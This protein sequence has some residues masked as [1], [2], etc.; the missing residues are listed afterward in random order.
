MLP[1]FFLLLSITCLAQT[2]SVRGRVSN[3]AGEALTG[4]SISVR[5]TTTGTTSDSNGNYQLSNLPA[6]A[7]LVFSY[8]GYSAQEIR[9]DGRSQL[10]VVMREA[11]RSLQDVVVV[12]SRSHNRS[13]TETPVA[14][15][16][17]PIRE[18]ALTSGQLDVNQL[19]QLVAPSFNANRQ[20][21]SDGS[22]HVDP[23]TIR[24]LGPDQTLVL[25]NGKRRHQSALINI[26][27]TRGRGNT[28]TDLNTIPAAA[29]ERIEI[30]RDGA[31]AQYGSDAIAGVI[32][33][34]LKSSVEEFTSSVNTGITK[35]GDGEQYQVNG[36][37]GFRIAEKGFANLT[38]DYLK[39]EK[40]NR[41]ADPAVY[42]IYR[43]Q[44][45]DASSDNFTGIYNAEIPV[46]EQASFYTFGTF[47]F[48]DTDAFA[49]TR[50][51]D[52]ERNIPAIYP[53]G[54]DP[55]IQSRI[56]DRSFSTG[57]KSKLREW[58]LDLNNTF[59]ANRFHYFVDG[60]LNASLL[61]QS[62]TRFDAGGFELIQNT[63]GLHLTRY[64]KDILAGSN[65]AF[66]TEYRI[67]NYEI[68]AGEEGSYRNYGII[69]T[70][71]NGRVR[72]VDVL[73][74]AAGSQGFPGFRPEN[75]LSEY[76]TNIGA[77]ADAE[78]DITSAFMVAA[79]ARFENY[80]DFGGTLNGKLASRLELTDNFAI[81]GS[82]STGFRAPSLAQIY[83]NTTFTDFVSGQPV[84]KVISRNN[85]PLTRRLG[86]PALKHERSVNGSLGFTGSFRSF[87]ATV[88]GYYVRI[89]DRIVL[90]GAF[91][92]TDPDIGEDL[93]AL[94]VGAGQFFTNAVDT[95]TLGV[96]V[97]LNYATTFG[98]DNILNVSFAGNFNDLE[99]QNIATTPRLA[100]KEDT[101]FGLR[102]Q[103]FLLA[104]APPSRM[105][106]IFDYRLRDWNLN[107]KFNRF[108]EIV[109]IDWLGEE[110]VYKPKVTTDL[111]IAK[112]LSENFGITLGAVNLF[113]VYPT[114]QDTETE[115][116]GLWDPVQMGI[117]GAFYY[118]R[119]R[120]NF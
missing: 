81:R 111:A 70:V 27:G 108:G 60:T 100:G 47:N 110:D 20:S 29:I 43:R 50:D 46:N 119:L 101:Y 30:L 69:D 54:F 73:G 57:F 118:A 59:G 107:L 114:K 68:F 103:R 74:R 49:W 31:A 19:L 105:N 76:R 15:D 106:L 5:G 90:T 3:E 115:S 24:G 91:E 1:F 35:E 39:R 58:D 120:F 109:L 116:G 97:I 32:N 85:S 10:N 88:D 67:E 104:S 4:V 26:F 56:L 21:G 61:E 117:G 89:R 18:I 79:A 92:D 14:I 11:A 94:G 28:G 8:I 98:A 51:A 84:D 96:D 36:N 82:V 64:F 16:I 48:R 87:T 38:L 25:V 63:T 71:I 13:V 37:Y 12:G 22:D 99:I 72:Q 113:D 17:I 93:Q 42:D 6:D 53:N 66:G 9:L 2:S 86:I 80:S 41:P 78:F 112:K 77:Y 7:V 75:E 40:T 33:I 83:F 55:H 52:S 45:G 102:E 95:R 44:F 62:P 34:V 23:A 65:F